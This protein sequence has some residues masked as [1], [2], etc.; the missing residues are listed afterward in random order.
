MECRAH[1]SWQYKDTDRSSRMQADLLSRPHNASG[2]TNFFE[3]T[4]IRRLL[5]AGKLP[6]VC[7]V[8]AGMAGL[9]CADVLTKKG[10]KVTLLEARNR[11]GGRVGSSEHHQSI[12]FKKFRYIKV[13][14]LVVLWICKAHLICKFQ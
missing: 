4:M 9:R 13:Q 10:V 5:P 1:K 6:H 12:G 11:I 14:S 8:G 3:D 2:A 7:I